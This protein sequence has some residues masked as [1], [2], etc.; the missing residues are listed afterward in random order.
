MNLLNIRVCHLSKIQNKGHGTIVE[1]YDDKIKVSFDLGINSIFYYP[2]SF[3]NNHLMA[4]DAEIQ[5]QIL[6]NIEKIDTTNSSPVLNPESVQRN[7]VTK[8]AELN[9]EQ[10]LEKK[11]EILTEQLEQLKNETSESDNVEEMNKSR[12]LALIRKHGYILA[13][14]KNTTF[15]SKN[16][17]ANT[18]WAN[19]SK[20]ILNQTWFLILNDTQNKMLY[21]FEIPRNKIS[22]DELKF[23]TDKTDD[24]IDLQLEYGNLSFIDTRSKIEFDEYLR[25]HISYK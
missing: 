1:Q 11:I 17:G 24:K 20:K 18:Y 9:E 22:L 3:I 4:V 25:E 10:L 8:K 7:N 12:A 2:Q 5:K 15:A 21:V 23:R 16:K 19:P 6:L 13:N 14:N